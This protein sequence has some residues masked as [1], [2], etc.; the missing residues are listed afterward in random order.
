MIGWLLYGTIVFAES[1]KMV[2][3]WD[4]YFPPEKA[5][6]EYQGRNSLQYQD[7][8]LDGI[9]NDALIWYEF[10]MINTL[11]PMPSCQIDP[12]PYFRY[13]IDRPSARFYG[14]L[15]ARFTNVSHFTEQDRKGNDIPLFTH[16]QQ[17]TVQG[18]DGAALNLYDPNRPHNTGRSMWLNG[19]RQKWAD[20]TVMV[21]NCCSEG[22]SQTFQESEESS[23]NFSAI[24]LWKK[25]DFV[26][27]GASA[28]K[29]VFDN[30]SKFLADVTRFRS[31]IEEGRFVVQ[32][33]E[34]FW[35]SEAVIVKDEVKNVQLA[36]GKN[37]MIVENLKSG[38][39]MELN[40][41]NSRWAIY[42]PSPDTE[43]V[44]QRL[45]A[46]QEMN[47]NPK[48]STAVEKE[49]YYRDSDE[50]L[51][52]INKIEFNPQQ[53]EFISHTFS[54]VRAV[55]IYFATYPFA[56]ES[57]Q[58]VFDNFQVYAAIHPS[59]EQPIGIV[60]G[61]AIDSQGQLTDTESEFSRE[62]TINGGKV[63]VRSTDQLDIRGI[64][65][66]DSQHVDKE[67]EIIVVVSYQPS[68]SLSEQFFMFSK[69]GRIL[70][71]DGDIAHLIAHED[72]EVLRDEWNAGEFYLRN[73]RLSPQRDVQIFPMNLTVFREN[74]DDKENILLGCAERPMTYSGRLEGLPAGT[75]NFF[76]GYR[77]IENGTL[78]FNPESIQVI[79]EE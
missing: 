47:F 55:G 9:Y 45:K 29:V 68:S 60:A 65:K 21:V 31:N 4:E 38:A 69:D 10:S 27:G 63:T 5:V 1:V 75:L 43:K 62:V 73:I 64:I 58:L 41:L 51:K 72:T 16:F 78:V 71:W 32:D 40:P 25:E 28:N 76:Y 19:E 57:T 22:L 24:F 18:Q 7:V 17:A 67:A 3:W 49:H 26:N 52:E 11:N 44:Q 48:K 33:G 34:Q 6:L 13:R 53:A 8:N 35:M 74:E 30:T 42:N 20:I 66:I 54:D 46:L 56:H 37:G 2:H 61:T 12:K 77:L 36:T 50:L 79:L 39:I 23:V 70:P 59:S 14:G 15:V